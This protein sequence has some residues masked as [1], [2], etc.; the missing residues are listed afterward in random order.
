MEVLHGPAAEAM[1]K[2]EQKTQAVTVSSSPQQ[3]PTV[4][5]NSSPVSSSSSLSSSP[6][7]TASSEL[8]ESTLKNLKA[9]HDYEPKAILKE[10]NVRRSSR[11]KQSTLVYID[12]QP[13]LAKNNY[14]VEGLGYKFGGD[15]YQQQPPVK[16]SSRG[17]AV[18][19]APPT[20]PREI[21]DAER[22]RLDHNAAIQRR[23]DAKQAVKEDFL[24]RSL[25]VMEPFL[26]TKV[27][28]KYQSLAAATTTTS[29]E[30]EQEMFMQPES[31]TA[32]LRDYQ[33]EGLNWM[34]KMHKKNL[35]M[36][37]G[38]EMGL[39]RTQGLWIA[40]V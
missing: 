25:K 27:V 9:S 6:S 31:I 19:K 40:E 15:D 5:S 2:Q 12:G 21:T 35:G 24:A 3:A 14:R 28:E 38:D 20:V 37:L 29:S 34:A 16:K 10:D 26:D 17:P 30:D 7:S 11:E 8:F 1:P 39:V 4:I 18:K 13:V 33:L 23:V 22:R 32:D 36:I